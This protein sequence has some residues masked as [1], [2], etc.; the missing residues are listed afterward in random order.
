MPRKS[1]HTEPE[2][3]QTEAEIEHS[4]RPLQ[5]ADFVGQRK[6]VD[7]LNIFIEAARK[8]GEPLDHVLLTGP[9]GLGKTTLAYII[10]HAMHANIKITSGPAIDKPY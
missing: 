8:R 5:F 1:Q 10:A 9:P 4:L 7:N 6:I 3:Q 2:Q